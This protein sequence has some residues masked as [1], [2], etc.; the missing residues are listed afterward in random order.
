MVLNAE[1]CFIEP[2][3][4][5]AGQVS[6]WLDGGNPRGFFTDDAD[7]ALVVFDGYGNTHD[8]MR[9]FFGV[10]IKDDFIIQQ[11]GDVAFEWATWRMPLSTRYLPE[12]AVK[13]F[14]AVAKLRGN[15]SPKIVP[16]E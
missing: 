14:L 3:P 6:R 4:R 7:N 12:R 9:R 16:F 2:T 11:N 5:E 15:P 8:S 13:F 1:A 10:R